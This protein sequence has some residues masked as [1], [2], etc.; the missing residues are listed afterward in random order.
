MDISNENVRKLP[1]YSAFLT[2][3][4]ILYVDKEWVRSRAKLTARYFAAVSRILGDSKGSK[5]ILEI[6]CGSGLLA[7]DLTSSYIYTGLDA[8]HLCIEKTRERLD[9]RGYKGKY[10]LI[11]Q[12]VRKF[13]AESKRVYANKCAFAVLKHFSL[14]EL[15]DIIRGLLRG[16]TNFIFSMPI[17]EGEAYD[18]GTEFHHV[19]VPVSFLTHICEDTGHVLQLLDDS[20]IEHIYVAS[21]VLD[22]VVSEKN[23]E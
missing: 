5:N 11:E 23:A 1:D 10:T 7:E 21:R 12:D 8:N 2:I 18:N 6:G 19:F 22:K 17:T 4:N 13:L 20:D 9:A 14:H 3:N 16:T 15:E